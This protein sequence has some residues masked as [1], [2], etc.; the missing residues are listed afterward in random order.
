LEQSCAYS[1]GTGKTCTLHR[2]EKKDLLIERVRESMERLGPY[3]TIGLRLPGTPYGCF[4]VRA[5]DSL[6]LRE[7]V[8]RPDANNAG[9]RRRTQQPRVPASAHEMTRRT[10]AH[11]H[12]R[13]AANG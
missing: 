10:L 4:T 3:I 12:S 5:R 1:L 13:L 8:D 11:C 7:G 9:R 6:G 2:P